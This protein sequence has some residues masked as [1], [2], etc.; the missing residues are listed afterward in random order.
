MIPCDYC[1][2]SRWLNDLEALG[3]C[4]CC[5]P[6]NMAAVERRLAELEGPEEVEPETV[7]DKFAQALKD[8]D[9]ALALATEASDYLESVRDAACEE[10]AEVDEAQAEA[11]A[12][13]QAYLVRLGLPAEPLRLADPDLSRLVDLLVYGEQ[14]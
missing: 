9:A 4:V 3:P 12:A 14:P 6:E 8:L 13:L 1:T 10:A 11:A 7:L 2:G 5:T